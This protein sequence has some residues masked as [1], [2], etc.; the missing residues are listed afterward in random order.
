MVRHIVGEEVRGYEVRRGG[1]VVLRIRFW[2]VVIS[3]FYI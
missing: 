2:S 1:G 3:Y